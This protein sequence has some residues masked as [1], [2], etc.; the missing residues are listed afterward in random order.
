MM[1]KE[2]EAEEEGREGKFA[3]YCIPTTVRLLK[4][5]VSHLILTPT[6]E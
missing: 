5:Y 4:T 3:T 1:G 2:E 6:Y